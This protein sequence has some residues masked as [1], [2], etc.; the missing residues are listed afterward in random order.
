M[1]FS[2]KR[3]LGSGNKEPEK[4]EKFCMELTLLVRIVS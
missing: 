3:E 2:K 1:R 4:P